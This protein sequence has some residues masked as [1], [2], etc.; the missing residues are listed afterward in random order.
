[1]PNLDSDVSTQR[2]LRLTLSQRA[3]M[4]VL[5]V[6]LLPSRACSTGIIASCKIDI[7][8]SSIY[9][10]NIV[11]YSDKYISRFDN[12]EDEGRFHINTRDDLI[13]VSSLRTSVGMRLI[14][15]LNTTATLDVRR[16]TYTHNP[17]KD[18][19]SYSLSIRQDLSKQ[20]AVTMGY[21]F[22]PS[23]YV[24]HYRD[25]DWVKEYGYTPET[26]QPFGFKKDEAS[27]SVQY[28]LSSTRVTASF[29]YARYYY[30]EH[31]TEYDSKNSS[32]DVEIAQSISQTIK[33]TGDAGV[34]Y[35]RGVGTPDMDPS[36]HENTF[37]VSATMVLPKVFGRT[38][39]IEIGGEYARR[40]FI[41]T[42]YLE[43]DPNHAGRRDYD[44]R[45]S[46]KYTY[47][48]L[49]GFTLAFTYA[50]HRR[51]AVTSAA[52]NAEYL[53]EEKDYRQYQIGLDLRYTLNVLPSK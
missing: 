31:F 8:L 50:W 15:S 46:V 40:V 4:L 47:Q 17:I 36:F 21:S 38:N 16:R 34:V 5:G 53:A 51:D 12:R 29:S 6:V 2:K 19:S 14:G 28:V 48:L 11:R 9:D 1:M 30:N 7:G 20:L 32:L 23:F 25:D 37:G 22:I 3:L 52:A 39:S 33:L 10:D 27:G 43:L 18:W 49:S 24:R 35:S 45:V 13:L 41:S 42:H 26:F 44:Y